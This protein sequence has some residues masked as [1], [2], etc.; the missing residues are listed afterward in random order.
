[1]YPGRTPW[2][3]SSSFVSPVPI[4][5]AAPGDTPLVCVSFA[6]AW[7]PLVIGG[8]LQLAQPAAWDTADESARS[9]VLLDVQDLLARFGTAEECGTLTFRF[10]EGCVL[11][12]STDGGDTWTDV[13]GW[14]T[15]APGCYT[16]ATGETGP[17]GD[18]GPAPTFRMDGCNL[19]YS[20][21]GGDTWTTVDG[22]GGF[23]STCIPAGPPANPLDLSTDAMACSI[24]AYMATEVINGGIQHVVDQINL[25]KTLVQT[26]Q[27]LLGLVF[28]IDVP[29]ALGLELGTAAFNLIQTLNLTDLQTGLDSAIYFNAVRCAIY[30]TIQA[31]GAITDA[32]WADVVTAVE[33]LSAPNAATASAVAGYLDS[34]SAATAQ[35]LQQ[36]GPIYEGDCSDCG[37]WCFEWDSTHEPLNNDWSAYS[38]LASF[39]SNRWNTVSGDVCYIQLTLDPTHTYNSIAFTPM[40]GPTYIQSD[41]IRGYSGAVGSSQVFNTNGTSYATPFTGVTTLLISLTPGHAS[42]VSSITLRG[43]GSASEFGASNCT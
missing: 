2:Q 32:N 36:T 25:S 39:S 35:W 11:Q 28:F 7:L 22:W 12:Y 30:A 21:D 42:Y 8:L 29:I 19:Q 40:E 26:V 16:G 20:T 18:P 24:A 13:D 34:M 27:S 37:T 33:A 3:V 1:M 5:S 15:S 14:P 31:D 4:P 43:P 6:Q 23:T 41:L 38:G 17:Q 10:T 9:A